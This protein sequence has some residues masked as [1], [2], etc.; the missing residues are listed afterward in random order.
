MLKLAYDYGYRLALQEAGIEKEAFWGWLSK[1]FA[2]AAAQVAKKAPAA[3][4]DLLR[5]PAYQQARQR[6]IAQQA[7]YQSPTGQTATQFLRQLKSR[8]FGTGHGLN[9]G[10]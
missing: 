3:A 9:L 5:S 7:G 10:A 1:M 6:I 8:G 4:G 2:P